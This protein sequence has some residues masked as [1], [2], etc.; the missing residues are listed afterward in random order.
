[1]CSWTTVEAESKESMWCDYIL[2]K[3]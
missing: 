3:M 1:M 2:L